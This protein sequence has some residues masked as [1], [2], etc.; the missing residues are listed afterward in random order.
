MVDDN[1]PPTQANGMTGGDL[2]V[3]KLVEGSW[4]GNIV[5]DQPGNPFKG[6]FSAIRQEGF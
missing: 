6:T 1:P 3:D 2:K 5:S 4:V